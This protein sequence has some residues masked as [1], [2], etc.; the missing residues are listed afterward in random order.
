MTARRRATSEGKLLLVDATAAWCGPC[1]MMDRTTWLDADVIGW[2]AERAIAIQID[3]DAEKELARQLRIQA[4]P[5][6]IAFVNGEELDR[7][8]GAKKPKELLAWLEGVIRGE[9]TLATL[10][11]TVGSEPQNMRARFDLARELL[12]A[13]RQAEA[14][15]GF[16]W[17]WQH[18]LEH[19]PALYGVRMSFL[20]GELETLAKTYAP[21]RDAIVDLRDRAE[22]GDSGTIERATF[23]DW[24]RLNR[25]LGEPS[26]TLAWYDALPAETRATNA[27]IL[28]KEVISL[29]VESGRLSEAGTL[30]A[31][32]VQSINR[33]AALLSPQ[34]SLPPELLER[35]RTH[36][37]QEV[38]SI[39][40]ALFAAQRVE[41]AEAVIARAKELDPSDGMRNALASCRSASPSPA[42]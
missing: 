20:A 11:R 9:S 33:S 12:R 30:Y 37:R 24:T 21:A 5:T 36:F 22:P 31:D 14:L 8:V 19:E 35:S 32:P 6:M 16:L 39:V 17:L 41:D 1:Q 2:L 34:R 13:G 29:L 10:E 42:S 7:T 18:M 25:M 23:H 3:V 27:Q 28:E 38:C 40:R 26:R 4:M 15:A